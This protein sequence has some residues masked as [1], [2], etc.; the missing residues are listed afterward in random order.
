MASM[1]PPLPPTHI[2]YPFYTLTLCT[3]SVSF[4]S[5][6]GLLSPRGCQHILQK[7][8]AHAH[9]LSPTPLHPPHANVQATLREGGTCA[10]QR[11]AQASQARPSWTDGEPASSRHVHR[12][13]Q[14][15]T[16]QTPGVSQAPPRS[17]EPYKPLSHI[18][19]CHCMRPSLCGCYSAL[20]WQWIMDTDIDMPWC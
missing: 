5:D 8:P 10:S 12:P 18:H 17:A 14:D 11:V 9:F 2:L 13:S 1:M 19:I 6:H 16:I 3:F 20:S 15:R 4:L 7:A